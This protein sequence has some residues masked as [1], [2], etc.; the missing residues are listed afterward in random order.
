MV[1]VV[2][3]DQLTIH[4]NDTHA[5][6]HTTSMQFHHLKLHIHVLLTINDTKYELIVLQYVLHCCMLNDKATCM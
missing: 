5:D 3:H 1:I 4:T 2:I 6:N